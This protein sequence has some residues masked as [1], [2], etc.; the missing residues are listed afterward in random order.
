MR[1][2]LCMRGLSLDVPD[3]IESDIGC[4]VIVSRSARSREC[5]LLPLPVDQHKD[6]ALI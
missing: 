3:P 1:S 2:A 6:F 5:D 4:L